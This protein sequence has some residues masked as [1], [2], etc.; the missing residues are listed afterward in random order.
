MSISSST[1]IP[2]TI[3]TTGNKSSE[4]LGGFSDDD[5]EKEAERNAAP[6]T[7][8]AVRYY[9]GGVNP[10]TSKVSFQYYACDD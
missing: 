7:K 6:K 5:G 3:Y 1:S 8:S 4:A 2:D 10:K 9:G